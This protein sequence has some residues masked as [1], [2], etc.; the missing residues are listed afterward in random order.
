[1]D[2]GGGPSQKRVPRPG[3][4]ASRRPQGQVLD[5]GWREQPWAGARKLGKSWQGAQRLGRAA[6]LGGVGWGS[7]AVQ[8]EED[9]HEPKKRQ[10]HSWDRGIMVTALGKAMKARPGACRAHTASGGCRTRVCTCVS[11][12]VYW[13]SP[14]ATLGAHFPPDPL[15]PLPL[16]SPGFGVLLCAKHQ[17]PTL[18]VSY[19]PVSGTPTPPHP[20][21]PAHPSLPG[22]RQPGAAP[23]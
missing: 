8:P 2:K 20:L 7:L 23:T 13:L 5:V 1:M 15:R 11:A 12:C 16:P 9:K 21:S 17:P 22:P 19:S 18:K 10:D 14:S 3:V 4:P 6:G